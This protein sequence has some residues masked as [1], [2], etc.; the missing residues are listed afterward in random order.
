[1]YTCRIALVAVG[2]IAA[3]GCS[4]PT[5]PSPPD[6]SEGLQFTDDRGREFASVGYPNFSGGALDA[7]D[8]AVAFP[9]SVGGLVIS[10]FEAT[11]GSRG[12]LFILQLTENRT[13]NFDSCGVVGEECHGRLLLGI[14][15]DNVVDVDETWTLV[16]GAV[17][18]TQNAGAEVI[19]TFTDLIFEGPDA[20][21]DLVV[22]A[23]SFSVPLLAENDGR[24]ILDCFLTQAT[25][26]TCD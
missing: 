3:A 18:I 23:G 13:G 17:S 2:L 22:S 21:S 6:A 11:E 10:S 4:D 16:G 15:A 19:G 25:G 24:A 8:F 20:E 9:D 14:D 12:N 7:S 5:V 26:G 1:M